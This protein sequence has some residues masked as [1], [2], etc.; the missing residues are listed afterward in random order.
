MKKEE[1]PVKRHP[2]A[3]T[4]ILQCN[5]SCNEE[6]EP[7]EL[8]C[9]G[10]QIK[11]TKPQYT[12]HRKNGR[13]ITLKSER[14]VKGF[15]WL[16]GREHTTIT[17]TEFAKALSLNGD[18]AIKVLHTLSKDKKLVHYEHEPDGKYRI[19]RVDDIH[20]FEPRNE[21]SYDS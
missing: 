21:A 3:I 1:H 18:Q 5:G 11:G 14:L 15:Q 20:R 2:I 17:K 10:H 19:I 12:L 6:H 9:I 16:Q 13:V 7:K 4:I 8:S